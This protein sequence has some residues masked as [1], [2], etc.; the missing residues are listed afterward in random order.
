MKDSR[1]CA[2]HATAVLAIL[3]LVLTAV[4]AP[5]LFP[6]SNLS[7]VTANRDLLDPSQAPAQFS[8]IILYSNLSSVDQSAFTFRLHFDGRPRGHYRDSSD[9]L[10]RLLASEVSIAIDGDAKTYYPQEIIVSRD[11]EI[12]LQSGNP[13][14]YPFDAYHSSFYIQCYKKTINATTL[15]ATKEEIPLSMSLSSSLQDWNIEMQ[16]ANISG[17]F[18]TLR[19]SL[20]MTRARTQK[21]FS[22]FIVT[23]V[24]LVAGANADKMWLMSLGVFVMSVSH[25]Y[26]NRLVESPTVVSR[27][28]LTG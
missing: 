20:T 11:I 17:D 22:L 7:T 23:L 16:L 25:V 15:A 14:G 8:G 27:L 3:C 26:F 13:E 18:S 28:A 24:G 6:L 1:C 19:V 2:N 10:G 9:S 21:F 5:H 4:I 12:P